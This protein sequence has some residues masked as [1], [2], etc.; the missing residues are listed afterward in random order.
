MRFMVMVKANDDTEAGVLPSEQLLAEMGRYNE[1]LVNH[2]RLQGHP[3]E[4]REEAIECASRAP[5]G[6]RRGAGAAPDPS[7]SR[8]SPGV[9]PAR[10]G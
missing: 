10:G 2:R 3:G 5:F 7:R 9:L 6:P 4:P 8:T 1:E